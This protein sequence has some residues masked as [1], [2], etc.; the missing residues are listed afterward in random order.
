MD[1]R[2]NSI[3]KEH[4]NTFA[5]DVPHLPAFKE[6][7]R[8]ARRAAALA[9]KKR[10]YEVAVRY[11]DNA[12]DLN[13]LLRDL[14]SRQISWKLIDEH[15][16]IPDDVLAVLNCSHIR[17]P[18]REEK[19]GITGWSFEQ[20]ATRLHEKFPINSKI[21]YPDGAL[22]SDVFVRRYAD[23][24]VLA[25]DMAGRNRELVLHRNNQTIPFTLPRFGVVEFPGW[26]LEFDHPHS[27][28]IEFDAAR[29]A[30]ITLKNTQ[31]LALALR[32][33]AGSAE[34]ELDGKSVIP[35]LPCSGLPE[36][37]N[38]LYKLADLGEVNSG[39]HTLV[40]KNDIED[41]GFLPAA[42][43]LGEADLPDFSGRIVQYAQVFIPENALKIQTNHTAPPG[44]VEL[45]INK[46]SCGTRLTAPYEWI[47]PDE[48]RGE[49]AEIKFSYSSSI[50]AL[51]GNPW[52]GS[53]E[54]SSALRGFYAPA[55][56]G[57][58]DLLEITFI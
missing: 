2:G 35:T 49:L 56:R 24:M 46:K 7:G 6:W 11:T 32:D 30:V 4:Y 54:L 47:I 53:D 39:R 26:Q 3:K 9:G 57:K 1:P 37:F 5:W 31:K 36:S 41:F 58:P 8:I 13:N 17:M 34:V 29:Q 48:L 38:Q 18:L 42:I 19:Y 45:F 51:F 10:L 16:P 27:Q 50:A 21:C 12:P 55:Y 33:Y 15:D 14:A 43:L 23:G 22:V 40:L 28:R 44:D 52:R 25:V 20:I